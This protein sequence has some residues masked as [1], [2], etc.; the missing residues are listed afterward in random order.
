M[1]GT[2]ES[3]MQALHRARLEA[4]RNDAISLAGTTAK[5]AEA[6]SQVLDKGGMAHVQPQMAFFTGTYAR[7]MKDWGVIEH[8]QAQGASQRKAPLTRFGNK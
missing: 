8:L 4:I 5:I 6:I 2:G 3:R 1:V 7:M